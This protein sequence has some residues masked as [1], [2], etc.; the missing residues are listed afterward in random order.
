M[1]TEL[2]K[3]H[4]CAG[5]D[6]TP[7]VNN[8]LPKESF[9]LFDAY[10]LK[11]TEVVW[12]NKELI[13]EYE[14]E[15]DEEFI[16]SELIENFS[17]VSKGYAK[18]TRIITNDK[19]QFMADQYGSRHEICNGGSARCGLNGYF[20]IKGI[21]RNPLV[22]ANMSESH[23]HG[24]LFIDEAI[25]E[26]IWGEICHKHLPYGA[27][28]TLAIIKTNVKHKF[29]YLDDA[30]DK[31]CALA[32][33]EV[34]VRPAHFE[35]C[36]FFWP[37]ESYS[38]LRDNDANR[39][40]KAAPFFSNLLLGRNQD[41]SLGDALN[42]MIDRLACQ[43]AASRVKGIPHGSLTSSNISVDGRFLDF[44]TITAVPDF[45]N[46]VLANGVGAVWDDHELIE[47]WLVNFID[48]VN[49][50]SGGALTPIRIREYSSNFSRLLDEYENK[51]LLIELGVEGHSESI[52]HQASFL[53][54]RLKSN[55]RRFITRFNDH[56]FRQR[57]LIEAETLGFDVRSVEFPLR[58]R[59]YSSFT[60]L[61]GHFNTKYDYQSVSQLINSY[62][63]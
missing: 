34:S 19:K 18:K 40:R 50:Y 3:T 31:H 1:A 43:I 45:G 22:A 6:N 37:D 4:K 2:L 36:T 30:P 55:E 16:K 56:E 7:F 10:K 20:Q 27:I 33:R 9:V 39:V 47:S 42:K 13:Q 23:S 58:K 63:S 61:Q 17:Y 60:M 26:A 35:R 62:L 14:I 5:E 53:K 54:D 21:G 28:R 15:F 46:Y 12:I 29:G 11:G 41:A 48:T 51:F 44:G 49:H 52:L 8:Y 24:K 32:I 25:S 57:V 59:K 38:Y